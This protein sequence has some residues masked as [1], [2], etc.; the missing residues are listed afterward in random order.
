[1][2]GRLARW[3]RILGFDVLYSNRF[4]DD[5]IIRIAAAEQRIVLTRDTRL[6]P[7]LKPEA[8]IFI[9]DDKYEDQV[10]QVIKTLQLTEFGVLTRCP[11]CN[12][13]LGSADKENVFERVAP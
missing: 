9:Q 4:D 8:A 1:M 12:T 7:R 10:A 6:F 11:E 5:E 3:L 2:V 13:T